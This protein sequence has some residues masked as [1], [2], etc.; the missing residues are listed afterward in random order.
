MLSRDQG[1]KNGRNTEEAG[2]QPQRPK[3]KGIGNL[4]LGLSREYRDQEKKYDKGKNKDKFKIQNK[5]NF[6]NC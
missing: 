3:K 4:N 6:I 2:S 1:K 5:N